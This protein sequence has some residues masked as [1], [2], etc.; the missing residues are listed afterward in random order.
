MSSCEAASAAWGFV[1]ETARRVP[2]R[3]AAGRSS[4]E[5]SELTDAKTLEVPGV[6]GQTVTIRKLGWTSLR[7]AQQ[8][9][10]LAGLKPAADLARE[11][12]P[13]ALAEAIK[14]GFQRHGGVE[15]VRAMLAADPTLAYDAATLIARSVLAWAPPRQHP[16]VER[17]PELARWLVRQ[18]LELSS[19]RMFAGGHSR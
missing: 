11:H 6:P 19:P 9:H 7:D 10:M 12:G 14:E 2:E 4:G 3:G 15:G 17:E 8:A 18:I 13:E 1:G 16:D 5:V